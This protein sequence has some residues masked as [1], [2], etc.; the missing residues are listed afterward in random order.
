MIQN[1]FKEWAVI[2]RGLAEGKQ[3]LILRKGGIAEQGGVFMPEHSRFWLYPTYVHQQR[4][5][6]KPE[7]LPLWRE[8][9]IERPPEGVLRLTHFA[10]VSGA[11]FVQR[12]VDALAL[13]PLHLWSAETVMKRFAYREPGIYVLAVRIFRVPRTYETVIRPEYDGLQNV[14]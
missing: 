1:A 8:A 10:E 12:L 5:G 9:E 4:D 7:A 14:G 13:E 6:I 11:F 2:C 3:A